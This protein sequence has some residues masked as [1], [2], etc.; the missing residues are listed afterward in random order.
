[1]IDKPTRLGNILDLLFVNNLSTIN[2]YRV[3]SIAI[4]D[5]E[6][7]YCDIKFRRPAKSVGNFGEVGGME[8]PS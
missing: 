2:K 3:Q 7:I 6:Q 4:S 5:H 8:E 1:V